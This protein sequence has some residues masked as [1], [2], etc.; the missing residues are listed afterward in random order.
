MRYIYISIITFTVVASQM[1][2]KVNAQDPPEKTSREIAHERQNRTE[3]YDEDEYRKNYP[4]DNSLFKIDTKGLLSFFSDQVIIN[5]IQNLQ[6]Q[7]RIS[8]TIPILNDLIIQYPNQPSLYSWRGRTFSELKRSKEAIADFKTALELNPNYDPSYAGLAIEKRKAGKQQEA[9]ENIKKALSIESSVSDYYEILGDIQ[10]DLSNYEEA[11][12]NYNQALKIDP[13]NATISIG[14]ANANYNLKHTAEARLDVLRAWSA[15]KLS[16]ENYFSLYALIDQAM[17]SKSRE[18]LKSHL[19]DAYKITET[20]ADAVLFAQKIF[21][22]KRRKILTDKT[23][24][25]DRQKEQFKTGVNHL[26]EERKVRIKPVFSEVEIVSIDSFFKAMR[27]LE[28]SQNHDQVKARLKSDLMLTNLQADTL[29][30]ILVEYRR[31][32][33][34]VVG[35]PEGTKQYEEANEQLLALLKEEKKRL[36][37]FVSKDQYTKIDL[38]NRMLIY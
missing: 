19:Q 17:P 29:V 18:F 15:I 23:L 3:E 14:R 38:Y 16:N 12:N 9:L 32:E 5:K 37:E 1:I 33:S 36:R 34:R 20:Q 30:A 2:Y 21:E 4:V 25:V 7:G 13:S 24:P 26:M 35:G 31:K 10:L 6:K 28:V 22:L 27:V 11:L 8:E